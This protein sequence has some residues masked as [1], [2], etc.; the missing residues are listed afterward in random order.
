MSKP[1]NELTRAQRNYVLLILNNASNEAA[2]NS[3]KD[4]AE[5]LKAAMEVLADATMFPVTKSK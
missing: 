2:L 4:N 1:W 5:A 3:L